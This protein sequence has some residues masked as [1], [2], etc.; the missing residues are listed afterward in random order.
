MLIIKSDSPPSY[1][2]ANGAKFGLIH[3]GVV[4][5]CVIVAAKTYRPSL[6]T[7]SS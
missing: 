3:Y 5:T 4:V 2:A 6:L 7:L 1:V